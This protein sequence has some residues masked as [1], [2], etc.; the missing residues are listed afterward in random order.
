MW[1][2][3]TQNA[4]DALKKAFILVRVLV[5]PDLTKP[6]QVEIDA[7][8]FTIGAIFSQL[9]DNNTLRLVSYYSRKFIT[10]ENNYP[11]HDKELVEWQPYLA[12][13]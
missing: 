4:F 8:D 10:L 9:D 13:A 3:A 1:T 6:F 2:S 7:S 5:H 11:M 12:R